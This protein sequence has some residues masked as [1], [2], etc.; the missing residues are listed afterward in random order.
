MDFFTA[1]REHKAR[2]EAFAEELDGIRSGHDEAARARYREIHPRR[3]FDHSKAAKEDF[4]APMLEEWKAKFSAKLDEREAFEKESKE[5]LAVLAADTPFPPSAEMTMVASESGGSYHTQGYGANKYARASLEALADKAAFH[6]LETEIR[7]LETGPRDRYGIAHETYGLFAPTT[8]E[9]A[10]LL[11][12]KQE[13]PLRDLVRM[14][15]KRGVNPRVYMPFLPHGYE[16]SQEID[17]F[18]NDLRDQPAARAP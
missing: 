6:G 1:H 13:V 11:A 2:L 18:G 14:S 4:Y 16:A 3:K 10:A 8:E 9:G 17:F 15:W 12:F 5:R 7:V